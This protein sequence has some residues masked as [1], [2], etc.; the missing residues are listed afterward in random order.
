MR[1]S[2]KGAHVFEVFGLREFG[3]VRGADAF[4]F[5]GVVPEKVD[6]RSGEDLRGLREGRLFIGETVVGAVENA[7]DAADPRMA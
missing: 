6:D 2:G 5:G 7:R 1:R 4:G 3:L